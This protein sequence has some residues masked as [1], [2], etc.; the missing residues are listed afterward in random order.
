MERIE[1]GENLP[2]TS[3][4]PDLSLAMPC[5]NEADVVRNTVMRLIQSFH[6]KRIAVELVLVDNGSVDGTGEIID[7]LITE[8]LPIVKET[9]KVNQ[10]YGYGVLRG[11]QFCRGKF[12]GFICADGQ[13][14]APDVVKVYEIVAHAKAPKL[15]KVRRR[16]RMDG[17]RRKIVSIIY[18]VMANAMFGGLG[19]ID[20]NGNPKIFPREYLEHMQ[21]GSKDWFLDAEV[22]I[23]AKQLGLDVFE[24]NVIAQMREGG[25]SHVRMG[26]CWEF[27]INLFKYRF[28]GRRVHVRPCEVVEYDN[29][30]VQSRELL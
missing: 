15:G 12:V 13:V 17:C 8:G 25:A 18:N 9:V 5:Y 7:K 24:M 21:L 29:V 1:M 30:P 11:I 2:A 22:L 3:Q 20:I 10:G 28:G 4:Q 27:V 23:K 14:D 16:F 6:E 19:S 26:T